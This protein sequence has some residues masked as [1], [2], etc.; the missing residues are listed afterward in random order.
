MA[1]DRQNLPKWQ[2]VAPHEKPPSLADTD[3]WTASHWHKGGES[4]RCEPRARLT[5]MPISASLQRRLRECTV[6]R[7][8]EDSKRIF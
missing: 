8:E 4:R 6:N 7:P 3:L 2:K 5:R 1:P